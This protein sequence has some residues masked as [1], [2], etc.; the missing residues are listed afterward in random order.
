MLY[1]VLV[2]YLWF[3][4]ICFVVALVLQGLS[5]L[6]DAIG[7]SRHNAGRGHLPPHA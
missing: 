1:T 7:R 2:W 4:A 3:I 5:D 6:W